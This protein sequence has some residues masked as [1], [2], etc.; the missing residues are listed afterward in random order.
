MISKSF[1]ATPPG[2]TIKE[3]IDDRGMTQKDFSKRMGLSEKH[4]SHLINGEVQL[5]QD[6]AYRLE[7]VLGV[8][9]SFW[10]NLEALYREDLVRVENENKMDNDIETSKKIPY[11][12]I[13][14]LGWVERTRKKIERV[15]NL[16]NFF[17]VSSLDLLFSE[18]LLQIACRKLDGYQEEDMKLLTWAQKAKLE[19]RNIDVDPINIAGLE[20]EIE[21]IRRLTISENPDFS[22]ILQEKL[23]KFGIALVYLP[24]LNGSFLHGATFYDSKKIVIGLTLRGKQSDKFWFSLFHELGHVVN[25]HINKLGGISELDEKESDEYARDKL[26]PKEKYKD[27]L[28]KG[29]YDRDSIIEFAESINISKGIVVGRLQKDGEIGY[30]QLNDLKTNYV[31][32]SN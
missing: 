14:K 10:N 22:I 24:H 30:N 6:V 15:I 2:L 3:Q 8:P 32:K 1:I 16:R 25:G 28:Q 19:A 12:E 13:S 23:K 29:R 27:F 7:M 31:F 11:N 9:A 5:T 18:N 26:I 17:E 20:D 4:I 21:N